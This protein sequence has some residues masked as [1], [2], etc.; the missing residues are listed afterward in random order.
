MSV[1]TVKTERPINILLV[2]EIRLMGNVIAA[3]L[4]DEVE[5]V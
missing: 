1:T 4:E 3:A 2:N 5:P